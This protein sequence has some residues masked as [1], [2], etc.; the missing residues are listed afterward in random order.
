MASQ[1]EVKI[2]RFKEKKSL[3]ELLKQLKIRIDNK[4][5]DEEVLREYYLSL[6]KKAVH[7]RYLQLL[8]L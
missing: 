2:R 6:L 8:Y 4:Q 7:Q 5:I 1:R 3:E